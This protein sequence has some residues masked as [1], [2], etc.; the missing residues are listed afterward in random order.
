[1]PILK[2]EQKLLKFLQ[3]VIYVY[4]MTIEVREFERPC[5][6]LNVKKPSFEEQVILFV[7]IYHL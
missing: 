4:V 5:L 7:V 3:G 1:M 6:I 2:L